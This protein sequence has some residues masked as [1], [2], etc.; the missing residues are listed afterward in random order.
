M[1][2]ITVKELMELCSE[3]ISKGYGNRQIYISRDDE[4]NGYHGLYYGFTE[5]TSQNAE[6]FEGDHG[7]ELA[8]EKHIILG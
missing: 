4:G 6:D 2:V 8:P 1:A 5:L 3:E 7:E